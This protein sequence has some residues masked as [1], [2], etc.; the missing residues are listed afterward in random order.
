M[1][2]YR[3]NWAAYVK[4]MSQVASFEFLVLSVSFLGFGAFIRD[5]QLDIFH[6]MFLT[7]AIWAL[8]GQVVL[9]NLLQEG[10]A[11]L[12]IAVAVS[13]TAIRFLPMMVS[14]LPLVNHPG[15]PRWLLYLLS[16]FVSISVWVLANRHLHNVERPERLPWLMGVGSV[17]WAAMLG[18]IVIG[19][20][21]GGFLPPLLSISL[22]FLTPTFFYISL[23]SGARIA[24]DYLALGVGTLL[25]PVLYFI[26]PQFDFLLAGVVGGTVAYF[27]GRVHRK[28]KLPQ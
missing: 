24:M 12:T 23:F 2:H 27:L 26:V 15:T 11:W 17:F 20:H 9:V 5:S 22:V 16:Y 19:Y 4:G 8:P 21:L 14:M 25:G 1:A 28:K 13:L 10:A 7:G 6:G 3:F 18:V